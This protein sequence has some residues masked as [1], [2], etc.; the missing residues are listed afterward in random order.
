MAMLNFASQ[1]GIDGDGDDD[2]ALVISRSS[3]KCL[4]ISCVYDCVCM[5]VVGVDNM[6]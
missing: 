1:I 6:C 2:G 3:I 4:T 5:C